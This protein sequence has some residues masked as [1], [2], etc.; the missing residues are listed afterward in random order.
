MH[1]LSSPE[2]N[3]RVTGDAIDIVYAEESYTLTCTFIDLLHL[4]L[5]H[6]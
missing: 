1:V 6:P 4:L 5:C 2:H 3:V